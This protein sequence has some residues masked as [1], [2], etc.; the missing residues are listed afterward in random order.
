[1]SY[2]YL[3]SYSFVIGK[4]H[5]ITLAPKL[6]FFNFHS[7]FRFSIFTFF[8]MSNFWPLIRIPGKGSSL[9]LSNAVTL[10]HSHALSVFD[11]RTCTPT[12]SLRHT[13]SHTHSLSLSL[14][15]TTKHDPP[16]ASPVEVAMKRCQNK[17]LKF[18]RNF[19]N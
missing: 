1:M 6:C 3:I 18:F 7:F 5:F 15:P 19:S 2:R 4:N 16:S 10:S 11:T 13:H 12:L 14:S 17:E 8:L 9:H